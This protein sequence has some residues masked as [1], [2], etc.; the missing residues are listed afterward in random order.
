M[1]TPALTPVAQA[2]LDALKDLLEDYLTDVEDAP[3]V[4]FFV[5]K[6]SLI[7]KCRDAITL[8][9]GS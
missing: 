2:L 5:E 6:D 3:G 4:G 9:E 1:K 8:A 7:K